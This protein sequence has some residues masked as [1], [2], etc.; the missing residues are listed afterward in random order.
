MNKHG[1]PAYGRYRSSQSRMIRMA[2]SQNDSSN[3]RD[4][5]AQLSQPVLQTL[6]CVRSIDPRID[7]GGDR[8]GDVVAVYASRFEWQRYFDSFDL[9]QFFSIWGIYH[10][11]SIITGLSGKRA[12]PM[13][14]T[15][16]CEEK[17]RMRSVF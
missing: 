1:G 5:G 14:F 4:P 2:V 11:P 9:H 12:P 13:F 15:R 7:Q 10:A 8:I 3:I 16:S 6:K 17:R